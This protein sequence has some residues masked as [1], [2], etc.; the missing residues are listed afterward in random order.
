MFSEISG[1]RPDVAA[2]GKQAAKL[3][4]IVMHPLDV[5]SERPRLVS[6]E[7]GADTGKLFLFCMAGYVTFEVGLSVGFLGAQ[8]TLKISGF[9]YCIML[10]PNVM[11]E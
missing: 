9:S 8:W 2:V 3:L 7:I 5:K 10:C 6:F 4:Y 11:S 1:A